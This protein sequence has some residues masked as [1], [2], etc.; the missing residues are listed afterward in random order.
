VGHI[1][2][3]YFFYMVEFSNSHRALTPA[4]FSGESIAY[5]GMCVNDIAMFV[6]RKRIQWKG[7][8]GLG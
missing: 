4:S 6:A 8:L 5:I 3:L 1:H 7:G 2:P